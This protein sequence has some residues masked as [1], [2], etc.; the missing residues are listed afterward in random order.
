[1]N[2][3][4]R[5]A[6]IKIYGSIP[7]ALLGLGMGAIAALNAWSAGRST[8]FH[9]VAGIV[10]STLLLSY[11]C[12]SAYWSLL[13][14]LPLIRRAW[15]RISTFVAAMVALAP[16]YG[17][18]AVLVFIFGGFLLI[19]PLAVI[20]AT[21]LIL[22]GALIILIGYIFGPFVFFGT[23][24]QA[25][26]IGSPPAAASTPAATWFLHM[27]GEN[28]GPLPISEVHAA[29]AARNAQDR[30]HVAAP[31]TETWTPYR[32]FTTGK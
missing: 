29:V 14:S 25:G 10:W 7:F 1:M 15:V 27:D 19:I 4:Q 30:A 6:R 31:G 9:S 3:A 23:L 22:G 26:F 16:A 11:T 12:W 24:R 8:S 17:C 18:L 28:H 13:G 20:I 32:S 5:F 21:V 2:S